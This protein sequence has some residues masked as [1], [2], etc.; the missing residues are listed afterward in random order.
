MTLRYRQSKSR[1]VVGADLTYGEVSVDTRSLGE[2]LDGW[3]LDERSSHAAPPRHG[4]EVEQTA[5]ACMRV[6]LSDDIERGQISER[7]RRA[8]GRLSATQI[9]ELQ[10]LQYALL[11]RE[12]VR[13]GAE[14]DWPGVDKK[15][16]EMGGASDREKREHLVRVRGISPLIERDQNAERMRAFR[17]AREVQGPTRPERG[18]GERGLSVHA[19]VA[20]DHAGGKTPSTSMISEAN[21]ALR[22]N[23]TN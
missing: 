6:C 20:A 4:R 2:R 19:P 22:A 16:L 7:I 3:G 23:D 5:R 10:R 9:E 1:R 21:E 11:V 18:R 17:P 15:I 8:G 12:A 13:A 14:R